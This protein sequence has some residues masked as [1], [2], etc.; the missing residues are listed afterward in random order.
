MAPLRTRFSPGLFHFLPAIRRP[1]GITS[2]P[3]FD[4]GAPTTIEVAAY[5]RGGSTQHSVPSR[6]RAVL[7]T[8]AARRQR[9]KPA[10]FIGNIGLAVGDKI[11]GDAGLTC[12]NAEIREPARLSA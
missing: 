6:Q 2:S 4:V 1:R 10:N 12:G 3:L 11:A 5:S 9:S 7:A 8:C